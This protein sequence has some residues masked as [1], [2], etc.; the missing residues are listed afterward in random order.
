MPLLNA[1]T[2]ET[3][4][5]GEEDE[6]AAN[7]VY[8]LETFLLI[9]TQLPGASVVDLFDRA[10]AL[11]LSAHELQVLVWA[12]MEGYRKRYPAA[13]V[14]IKPHKLNAGLKA[15]R[16]G[17]GVIPVMREVYV[18]LGRSPDLGLTTAGGA[19]EGDDEAGEG[20]PVDPTTGEPSGSA[21][22]ELDTTP[23]PPGI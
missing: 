13:S 23:L 6:N 18:A 8:T 21:S 22:S 4:L 12:G 20:E 19:N 15:I 10:R 1:M 11:R 2:G 3:V 16:E 9:E 17:G 7:I 5:G 14:G